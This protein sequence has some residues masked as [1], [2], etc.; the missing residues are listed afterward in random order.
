MRDLLFTGKHRGSPMGVTRNLRGAAFFGSTG[1]GVGGE[2]DR[3]HSII[4]R[5][6]KAAGMLQVERSQPVFLAL[7]LLLTA[8]L[9]LA[10]ETPS[11]EAAKEPQPP[12]PI[13][14]M[15]TTGTFDLGYR[16]NTG[17]RGSQDLY[18]SLVNVGDGPRLLGANLTMNSPLG[19]G[20]YI[21]R[22]QLNASAWGGDPY[23]TLRLFAE[24]TGAYQFS[25]DYRKVDY[26]NF[27]PS[28]ANPLLGQGILLGQHSF[29]STRRTMDFDLTLRPGALISPFIAYS[30]NSGFGPGITTFTADGNEFAVNNQLRDTS[31]YFRGGV[32]LNLSRMRLTLEQG[33]LAFKDDQRIFQTGGQNSGNRATPL[34]G[35]SLVLGQLDEN[36]HTR[37]TTPVSRVQLTAAPWDKLSV[38]GRFV[39]SQ[40]DVKFDYDR[41]SAG[42]FVSLD[43][44]RVFT[45][46]LASAS[47]E[48][49]RPHILG[50]LSVEFR[51]VDRVRVLESL[52]TDRFHIASSSSLARSLT[53]TRPLIGPADPGNTF[54]NNVADSNRF[55]VNLNQNQLESVVDLTSRISVRGGYRYVWSD[56][57]LRSLISGDE[58]AVSMSRHVGLAGFG[59]RLQRKADLSL[60]FEAGE[61]NRVYSP[62]DVLDYRKVRLR[63]RYRPWDVLTVSGALFL[64]DH[65]NARPDLDYDFRNHGYTLSVSLAPA[66]GKRISA[67]LDYSRSDLTSD[68]LFIIPQ[69]FAS[70]RSLYIEDS[71]YGNFS[72]DLG[73]VRGVRLSLG[74]GVLS[75]TGS[76]S[77]NYHQPQAGLVIPLS[78]RVAW[79][80]DWRYY[81]Y[82]EKGLAVQD[83]HNHL[84]TAGL[85]LSY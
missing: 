10:Q 48:A 73:I 8:P 63:G 81:G 12:A 33:V 6:K 45:G 4:S 23:N 71:Q 77:L 84:I 32:H 37:G 80:T 57:Q 68:I 54:N 43:V 79:T 34:L 17:L 13:F 18:R 29:D 36:Y 22:L 67:N 49:D 42:N 15:D 50:N 28:F 20:K 51:P 76:R 26:F 46:E 3:H 82:N 56:T 2:A 5:V 41:R 40:P 69:L 58:Q 27:I 65:K 38:A 64:M 61:G 1:R 60:D 75:T 21:D 59:F 9:L 35:Q 52:V 66:G 31:D 7:C 16:W 85:R 39:Y 47:S 30:R 44:L 70:D 72:L 55:A 53:G 14:G 11:L 24:K 19:T 74:Y 62:T 25:F 83:F 78:R